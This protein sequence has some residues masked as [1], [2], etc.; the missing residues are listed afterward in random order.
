MLLALQFT[1]AYALRGV[2]YNAARIALSER[3]RE[4]AT[5]RVIGF[6]TKETA[7]ILL[8]EIALLTPRAPG[9]MPGQ[10]SELVRSPG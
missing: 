4:L 5:M 2:S 10:L 1:R 7:Y 3:G 9:A 6:S 8:G